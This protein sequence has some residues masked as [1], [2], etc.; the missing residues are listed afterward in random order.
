M[1]TSKSSEFLKN[2]LEEAEWVDSWR[3]RFP[4]R[5]SFTWMRRKPC[6]MSCLDYFLMPLSTYALMQDAQIYPIT[7]SDHTAISIDIVLDVSLRGPGYWKMNNKHL[8]D[9]EFINQMNE[10]LDILD[11][12]IV[13][14]NLGNKWESTEKHMSRLVIDWSKEKARKRKDLKEKYNKRLKALYK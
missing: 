12:Q 9:K 13:N 4:N 8:F 11:N 14:Y 1:K 7:I 10:K 6:I 3:Q 5:F 2:F